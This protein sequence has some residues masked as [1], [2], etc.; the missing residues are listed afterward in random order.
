MYLLLNM[1]ILG[2]FFGIYVQFLGCMYVSTV[3]LSRSAH[4][5]AIEDLTIYLNLLQSC[6]PW[7]LE[8]VS[9][10]LGHARLTTRNLTM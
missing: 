9:S 6:Y 4:D 7:I 8:H 5:F 1:A 10:I 2:Y 3:C